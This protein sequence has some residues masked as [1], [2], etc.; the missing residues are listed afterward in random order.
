MFHIGN[1]LRTLKTQFTVQPQLLWLML[2]TGIVSYASYSL[3]RSQQ[4]WLQQLGAPVAWFGVMWG[5]ARMCI[6]G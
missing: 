1:D 3:V 5:I 4:Q 6:A 2:F